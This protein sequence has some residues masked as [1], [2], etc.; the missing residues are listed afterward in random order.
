[1]CDKI[2]CAKCDTLFT[3]ERDRWPSDVCTPC[4]ENTKCK[5]C[6]CHVQMDPTVHG[7]LTHCKGH[8]RDFCHYCGNHTQFAGI[9]RCNRCFMN[10]KVCNI[11]KGSFFKQCKTD[12]R[13]CVQ[14]HEKVPPSTYDMIAI[15]AKG[16]KVAQTVVNCGDNKRPLILGENYVKEKH[17]TEGQARQY[18]LDMYCKIMRYLLH[19]NKEEVF[20]FTTDEST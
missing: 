17:C 10:V 4:F 1:M 2:T 14:P 11:G 5:Q 7:G 12:N 9:I 13:E 16:R 19:L 6:G 20:E 15:S 8:R 3:E 18:A